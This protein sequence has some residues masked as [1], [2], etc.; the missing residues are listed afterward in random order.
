M[1][2]WAISPS[3]LAS[4][5][6]G[7]ASPFSRPVLELELRTCESFDVAKKLRDCAFAKHHY[8]DTSLLTNSHVDVL[9]LKGS[10]EASSCDCYLIAI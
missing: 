7:S 9:R 10:R 5:A 4:R 1:S 2:T 6:S 8:K 3:V